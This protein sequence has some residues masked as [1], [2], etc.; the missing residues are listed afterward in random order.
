MRD[1]PDNQ[2][3][4]GRVDGQESVL[5]DILERLDVPDETSAAYGRTPPSPPPP[6]PAATPAAPVR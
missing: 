3:A 5:V 1:V 2:E 4:F 6:P